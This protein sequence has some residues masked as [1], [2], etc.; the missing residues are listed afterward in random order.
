VYPA[1]CVDA[2]CERLYSEEQ[3]GRI[4]MGCAAGVF[5]AQIDVELFELAQRSRLGFGALRVE[6]DPLA[7]CRTA[8][9]EAFPHRAVE[10]CR[11]PEFLLDE[12]HRTTPN[13]GASETGAIQG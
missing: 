6:R 9:D 4:V 3:D 5:R 13:L 10:P 7:M 11:N 2:G 8:V 12:I 1:G